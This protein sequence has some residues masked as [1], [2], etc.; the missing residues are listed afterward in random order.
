M[1]LLIAGVLPLK[2]GAAPMGALPGS[3]SILGRI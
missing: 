1:K 3:D 2:T